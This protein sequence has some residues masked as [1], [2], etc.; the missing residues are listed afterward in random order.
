MPL[1]PR[2]NRKI[3]AT[4]ENQPHPRYSLEREAKLSK[5]LTEVHELLES[6]A[7]IWYTRRLK[8]KIEAAI[9]ETGT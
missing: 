7:P 4:A 2:R 3:G 1:P 5:V 8:T 6:Y 9:K